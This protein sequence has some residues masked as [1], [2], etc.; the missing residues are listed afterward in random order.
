MDPA[1]D[2]GT[3]GKGYNCGN[4]RC[5]RPLLFTDYF[6]APEDDRAPFCVRRPRVDALHVSV[7][8]VFR[9]RQAKGY[10]TPRVLQD[11]RIMEQGRERVSAQ[12]I[13]FGKHDIRPVCDNAIPDRMHRAYP[14]YLV[15]SNFQQRIT[16]RDNNNSPLYH[17]VGTKYPDASNAA[18]KVP[19][20]ELHRFQERNRWETSRTRDPLAARRSVFDLIA[21]NSDSR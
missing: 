8:G 13:G 11:R 18:G 20:H 12:R 16:P 2:N 9:R 6:P 14:S 21:H 19:H 5:A 17:L 15:H 4:R 1:V 3:P 10:R 7:R